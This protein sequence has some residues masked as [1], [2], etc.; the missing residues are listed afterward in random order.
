M[1]IVTITLLHGM[2]S[3]RKSALLSA[4]HNALVSIGVPEADRFQR[5]IE[6]A[7]DSFLFDSW[8]PDCRRSRTTDFVMIEIVW[9]LGRSVQIKRR[10]LDSLINGV[11]ANGFDPENLMVV[12]Q[13]TML[14]NWSFAGGR[15][16]NV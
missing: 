12:F 6:L 13:E 3:A 9:S 1:P 10:L 5:V 4:V 7:E 2:P 14:E 11:S 15:L 16:M 8:Y